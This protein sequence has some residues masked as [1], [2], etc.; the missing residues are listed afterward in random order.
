MTV[1]SGD[2][3]GCPSFPF[4]LLC[5]TINIHIILGVTHMGI[6]QNSMRTAMETHGYSEKTISLYITCVRVFARHFGR[7]PL[8]ISSQEIESFFHYL[9]QEHKSDSTIHSYYVSLRFFYRLN[10]LNDRM[11]KLTFA[12]IRNRIPMVLSQQKVAKMLDS[13]SSLKFKTIFTLGIRIRP[14]DL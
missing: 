3:L 10:N 2:L 14:P 9:R 6:L 12:K 8:L 11:P 13:C 1:C 7:S 5:L 4:R